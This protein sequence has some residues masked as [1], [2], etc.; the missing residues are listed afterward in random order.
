MEADKDDNPDDIVEIFKIEGNLFNYETPLCKAF[1]DLNYFLKINTDLFTFDIQGIKTYEEYALN[2]NMTR[3]LEEPWSDNEVPYQLC[4][5]ICEPYRFKN[6]KTK[7]PTCSLDIDGFCNDGE[8][9]GMIWI[10]IL[11]TWLDM[12]D[13][14]FNRLQKLMSQLK[15]LEEKFSQEDV[16]QKLLRSLSPEWNTHVVVWRNK[17]DLVTMSMDDLYDNLKLYELEVKWMSSSSS[18]T[19]Y[20]AFMSFLNN[21]TS[22]TNGTANT[23][24]EVYTARTQVNV[25][26]STNI[27]NLSDAVIC[28]FF[29]SQPN[30]PQLVHEDLEQ[31][32]PDDMEE[33]DLRWQMA[34]L[35]MRARRFLKKTKSKLT[36]NGNETIDLISPMWSATTAT[37]GDILL[38]SAKIQEIKTTR[39]RK[40]QEGSD[41]A[42]EGP[43]YALMVFSSSSSNSKVSNDSTC[44]KSCLETVKILKSQNDQLLKDLQKYELMVLVP[45]SYTRNFIPSTPDLSFTGLDEFVN[46]PAVENCKVKSSEE[47]PKRNRTLIEAARTMLADFK[48]PIT[49]WIEAVNTVCYVQNRVL[50]VKP[51]N[52]TPYELFHGRT[53]TLR[54]MRPFWC[55]VTI[56]NTINHL[57]KFDGKA[58]ECFFIGYS[59]NSKAFRVFNSRTRI[60][61]ENLHIRFSESTPNVVGTQSNGFADPKSS[62]DDG[63]K[64]SSDDG[65]KVDDDPR[66]ENEYNELPFEQNMPALEDVCTFDFSNDDKDN[67]VVADMNNMDTK[68]QVGHIPT[69]KIHKDHP[70]DQVIRDLQSATQTRKMSK[71]LEEHGFVS[72]I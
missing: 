59:L 23:A 35:T 63:I 44:S 48:L 17:A 57:G 43:H 22:S 8:L 53:P 25:A 14:T 32:H 67:V 50:V 49:F 56:L 3:D 42:E 45:P 27:D 15:L 7:W 28:L 72:T 9:P 39:T 30:S 33:M 46:K 20:M 66:K 18:G 26:Y 34:M 58:G 47:E 24:H 5:H 1:N 4:D 2:N 69:T 10:K 61:E 6:G 51:Y 41:Q 64:P 16:N 36:V 55:S 29:A 11:H 19:K 60:L 12:L 62:N 31:I 71:N 65:Q 37:R 52:K 40:A 68:I 54:F 38:G 70:L 13:Q 21:Y